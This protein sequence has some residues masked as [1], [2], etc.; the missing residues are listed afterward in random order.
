MR[1]LFGG[2]PVIIPMY[3]VVVQ[4]NSFYLPGS[5]HPESVLLNLDVA[6]W[7]RTL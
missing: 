7:D 2:D 5:W 6:F 1:G 3:K 4:E